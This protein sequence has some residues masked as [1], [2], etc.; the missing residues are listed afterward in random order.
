LEGPVCLV[1]T[2]VC[3]P[4]GPPSAGLQSFVNFGERVDLL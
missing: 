4:H 1:G 3:R 2:K